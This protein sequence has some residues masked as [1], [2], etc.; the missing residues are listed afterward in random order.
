M[1]RFYVNKIMGFNHYELRIG[2]YRLHVYPKIVPSPRIRITK[3]MGQ[4]S[5]LE[6][7]IWPRHK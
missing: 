2:V 4:L 5:F 6:L 3:I 1:I 7:Q